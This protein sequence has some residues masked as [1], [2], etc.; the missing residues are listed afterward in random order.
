MTQSEIE[1]LK[2]KLASAESIL[3]RTCDWL[4]T[5][6]TLQNHGHRISTRHNCAECALVN[7]IFDPALARGLAEGQRIRRELED[8]RT[9]FGYTDALLDELEALPDKS[10]LTPYG[11]RLVPKLRALVEAAQEWKP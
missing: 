2:A 5:N 3:A 11:Q 10:V 9:V 4:M 7:E 8:L 6:G 1:G